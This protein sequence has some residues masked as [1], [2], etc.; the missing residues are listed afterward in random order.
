MSDDPLVLTAVG[1]PCLVCDDGTEAEPEVDGGY[2]Y[3]ECGECGSAFDY[4][5]LPAD[6]GE[7][8][9]CAMGIAEDTRRRFSAPPGEA[10]AHS[11]GPTPAQQA[12][13]APEAVLR[14]L[15]VIMA[16][17]KILRKK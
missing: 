17:G 10:E 9:D 6:P 2:V 1:R 8:T 5:R 15:E 14:R 11:H 12:L 13:A 4:A 16:D 7:A 3:Y